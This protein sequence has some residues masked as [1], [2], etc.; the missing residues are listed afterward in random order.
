MS[1]EALVAGLGVDLPTAPEPAVGL[2]SLAST[3]LNLISGEHHDH[4]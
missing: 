4:I 2:N 1:L 3:R